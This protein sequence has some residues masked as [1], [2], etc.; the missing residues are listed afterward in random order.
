MEP[1]TLVR[2]YYEAIDETEYETLASLLAP[3]FRQERPDRTFEG[4]DSFVDFMRDRRPETETIH[5][6]RRV[7]ESRDAVDSTGV[8]GGTASVA[9]E[10]T[11][12]HDTGE[13]FFSFV[14]V[15]DVSEDAISHLRTYTR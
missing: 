2:Q 3:D 5:E 12:Y 7:F 4:R 8:D 10:G 13:V 1:T 15:F 11:V 6:V 9:V 14:D